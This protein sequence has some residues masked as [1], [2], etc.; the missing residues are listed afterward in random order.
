MKVQLSKK[1]IQMT[2]NTWIEMQN[3]EKNPIIVKSSSN[4][5][6]MRNEW[7]RIMN[8][9]NCEYSI[10]YIENYS[11][12]CLEFNFLKNYIFFFSFV[13]RKIHEIQWIRGEENGRITLKTKYM[14]FEKKKAWNKKIIHKI[15]KKGEKTNFIK[16]MNEKKKTEINLVKIYE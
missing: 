8:E 15:M 9:W 4:R 1:I 7:M 5:W 13:G 11:L 3:I 12:I 2:W 16:I 14:N 6:K 10:I